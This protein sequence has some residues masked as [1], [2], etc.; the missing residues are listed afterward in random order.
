M[1]EKHQSHWGKLYTRV[2]VNENLSESGQVCN[3][4]VFE[5]GEG[6]ISVY[7]NSQPGVNAAWDNSH[8]DNQGISS[9]IHVA[10][11]AELC[12]G[13]T[14]WFL[15]ILFQNPLLLYTFL[16]SF[17]ACLQIV[18]SAP[19]TTVIWCRKS[20]FYQKA[21]RSKVTAK[22]DTTDIDAHSYPPKAQRLLYVCS[23]GGP[24]TGA[25]EGL[26]AIWT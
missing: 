11:Q 25:W 14:H 2:S 7:E 6:E 13:N 12:E 9:L 3:N 21:M 18:P 5:N 4:V 10:C 26:Y 8:F 24:G 19:L 1:W 20:F 22:T 23:C 15:V 16:F 17:F